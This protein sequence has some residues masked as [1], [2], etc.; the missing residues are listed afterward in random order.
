MPSFRIT[1]AVGM[2]RAGV[3]PQDVLPA[4]ADAAREST[5]VEAY[6]LDVVAGEARLTVRFTAADDEEAV[7]VAGR[8]GTAVAMLGDVRS[9]KLTRR[10]GA[11]W[12]PVR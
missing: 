12:S 7:L 6:D 9:R 8:V 1:L 11:R 5:T 4:A 2:L 10:W 3:A